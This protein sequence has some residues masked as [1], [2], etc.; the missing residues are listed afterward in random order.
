MRLSREKINQLSKLITEG[1]QASGS[2]VFLRAPN[3]VRLQIV[4]LV[5]EELK[6]DDQVDMAVRRMLDSYSRRI[7]EGSREWEIEY[8]KRYEEEWNKRRKF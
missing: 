3:D 8:Q 7:V 2:V 4:Y 6:L 5:T 1:L